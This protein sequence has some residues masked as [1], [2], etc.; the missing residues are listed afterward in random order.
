MR[1]TLTMNSDLSRG[2]EFIYIYFW[3][4]SP[5]HRNIG[6]I[7]LTTHIMQWWYTGLCFHWFGKLS[8]KVKPTIALTYAKGLY[9]QSILRFT[10]TTMPPSLHVHGIRG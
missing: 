5:T 4:S 1:G 8:D 2:C 9:V 3:P 10:L 7:Q 6:D